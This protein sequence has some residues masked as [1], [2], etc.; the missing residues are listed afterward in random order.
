MWQ[1][2]SE[3]YR[4]SGAA[5]HRK[6]GDDATVLLKATTVE[7]PGYGAVIRAALKPVSRTQSIG[8]LARDTGLNRRNI[9]GA[10]S[11]DGDPTLATLLKVANDLGS[12]LRLAPM[13]DRA[14][15]AQPTDAGV[16][17]QDSARHQIGFQGDDESERSH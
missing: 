14:R 10:L 17:R 7:D 16:S 1:L 5:D 9:C 11:E 12:R 3:E 4:K 8:T 2:I 6:T 13:E 15:G